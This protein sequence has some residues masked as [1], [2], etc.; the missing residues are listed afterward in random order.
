MRELVIEVLN[1]LVDHMVAFLALLVSIVAL[2]ATFIQLEIQRKHNENSLRPVG[3]IDVKDK[4]NHMYVKVV[5]KG[6]GPMQVYKLIF[7]KGDVS[8]NSIEDCLAAHPKS[9]MHV[10]IS[11]SNLKTLSPND[12]LDVFEKNFPAPAMG[13]F[14][15]DQKIGYQVDLSQI[16]L[17]VYYKDIHNNNY[18]ITKNLDWF[19]RHLSSEDIDNHSEY[20]S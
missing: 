10:N 20:A 7:T 16:V 2:I 5:N 14:D 1:N 11:E 18:I 15:D 8:Y 3:Q 19:S 9:Y 17:T 13:F 12:S 4:L 6:L